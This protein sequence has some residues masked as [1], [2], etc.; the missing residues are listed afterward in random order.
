MAGCLL[1]R[2]KSCDEYFLYCKRD[3]VSA[4]G[5][6][7]R[8]DDPLCRFDELSGDRAAGLP[9]SWQEKH[10]GTGGRTGRGKESDLDPDPMPQSARK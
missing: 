6:E 10:V 2:K 9:A 3:F 5:M 7:D 8:A 1:C 4:D